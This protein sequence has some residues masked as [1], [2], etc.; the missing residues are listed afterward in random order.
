MGWDTAGRL[1]ALLLGQRRPRASPFTAH[2]FPKFVEVMKCGRTLEPL[3][4][5]VGEIVKGSM[6]VRKFG[7]AERTPI[8]RGDL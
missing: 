1:P 3:L 6:H 7:G 8:T 2:H 5:I 4:R